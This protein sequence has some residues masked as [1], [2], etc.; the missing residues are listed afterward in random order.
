MQLVSRAE[1][2]G[3]HRSLQYVSEAVSE[4]M[5]LVSRGLC[6]L[7]VQTSPSQFLCLGHLYRVYT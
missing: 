7:C 2:T 5:T 1:G 3:R 4:Q 6:G